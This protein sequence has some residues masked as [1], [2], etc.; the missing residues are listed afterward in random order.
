M[1]ARE[2][3]VGSCFSMQGAH[4]VQ[5]ASAPGPLHLL[6][7]LPGPLFLQISIGSCF[8]FLS[9]SAPCRLRTEGPLN[10]HLK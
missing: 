4:H 5:V 2:T 8:H 10:T 7:L 9:V 1:R 6:S 3:Y